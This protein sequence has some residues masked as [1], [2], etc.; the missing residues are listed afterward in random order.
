V[1]SS[2]GLRRGFFH[3]KGGGRVFYNLRL[4]L[5]DKSPSSQV[6]MA[7]PSIGILAK[8]IGMVLMSE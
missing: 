6:K 1:S 7:R 2:S 4:S 3:S 5:M 8:I